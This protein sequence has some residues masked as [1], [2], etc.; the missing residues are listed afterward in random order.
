[1]KALYHAAAVMASGGITA[2]ASISFEMLERCGLS[3]SGSK[4]VLLP[5]IEGTIANLSAVKAA[6]AL[7]GPVARGDAGTVEKNLKAIAAVNS[8]WLELYRLLARRSIEL[9]DAANTDK[10]RLCAMKEL[11]GS[12]R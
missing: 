10:Q 11:V 2:L 3:E 8:D 12:R 9:A 7:T 5:L 4:T 6:R 1:M